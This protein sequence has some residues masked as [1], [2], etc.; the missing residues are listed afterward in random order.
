MIRNSNSATLQLLGLLRNGQSWARDCVT[1]L[2]DDI[3]GLMSRPARIRAV[4][5][6][7]SAHT[8]VYDGRRS[9]TGES[10]ATF[11][12]R[13]EE[14][15]PEAV[16]KLDRS[17]RK[18]VQLR[19]SS[20]QAVVKRLILP[21]E[22]RDV[23][24]AIVRNKVEGLAPWPLPK[25][26]WGY[27]VTE[28]PGDAAHF[29]V[30]VAVV[31][32]RTAT[33][34]ASG[35]AGAGGQMTLVD[36]ADSPSDPQPIPL[37]LDGDNRNKRG[38]RATWTAIAVAAF[39]F[40]AVGAYGAGKVYIVEQ[41]LSEAEQSAAELTNALR[42]VGG[43]AAATAMLAEANRIRAIRVERPPLVLVLNALSET[44]PDAIWLTGLVYT[45]Q[46]V[47]LTGRGLNIT[48]LVG[49]LEQAPMFRNVNFASATQ[50]NSELGVDEFSMS[51]GI[52]REEPQ[53]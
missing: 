18:A 53:Q 51:A 21:A 24:S 10:L 33:E 40:I 50:R 17:L 32:R 29:A 7:S 14:A 19:L 26:V 27:R 46:N 5:F 9:G 28:M 20:S 12:G 43:Q 6:V 44:L 23:L 13:P 37:D 30:D 36:V 38:R 25:A 35:L 42:Q 52:G 41:Q 16:R 4:L 11:L 34:L 1:A 3:A 47:T 22:A 48:P 15:V 2:A 39:A 49:E 8:E 45:P 31:S